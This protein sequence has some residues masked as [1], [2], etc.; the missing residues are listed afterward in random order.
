MKP[1]HKLWVSS[2]HGGKDSGAV[3]GDITEAKIAYSV[4]SKLVQFC[5][6]GKKKVKFV[7]K[8]AATAD[9]IGKMRVEKFSLDDLLI[10]IH[11]NAANIK[12]ANGVEAWI[13]AENMRPM[14]ENIVRYIS[15][16]LEMRNRGVKKDSDNRHGSLG[17]LRTGCPAVLIELGFLTNDE[18]REKMLTRQNEF[19]EAIFEAVFVE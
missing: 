4:A 18:D 13:S 12:S 9:T 3:V 5:V 6:K 8:N 10:D 11:A 19:A 17:I 1:I 15:E 16:K 7:G 14:A 2:G